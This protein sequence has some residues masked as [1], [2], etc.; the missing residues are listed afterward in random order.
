VLAI[1][2]GDCHRRPAGAPCSRAII[3]ALLGGAKP[4]V[5][6][7]FAVDPESHHMRDP[8]DAPVPVVEYGDVERPYCGGAQ[9]EGS[10]TCH[11]GRRL[12][13][14][15]RTLASSSTPAA[16]TG[17]TTST[18]CHAQSAPPAAGRRAKLAASQRSRA[19]PAASRPLD[20]AP[21]GLAVDLMEPHGSSQR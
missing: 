6:L 15:S 2:L 18:P 7:E 4:L 3:A 13:G 10:A 14:V 1:D 9:P 17:P 8:L 20:Q 16:T 12:T 5:D 21:P 19:S 11:E